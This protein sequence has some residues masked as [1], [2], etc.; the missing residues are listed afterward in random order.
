MPG[1]DIVTK[2]NPVALITGAAQRIGAEIART[3][4]RAGMDIAL[5]Y[6]SSDAAARQLK[7][8]LEAAR[9]HSVRLIQA[10]LQ[11]TAS[12]AQ[13][14]DRVDGWRGRL[15]LLV[16]NASSF[17]P[18]PLDSADRVQWQELMN[19]N[20]TAP[21]FLSLAAAPLLKKRRGSIVNLVDI[22][23]DRPL[24]GH[25]I[26]SIAK[27]GSAMMV[28]SLARELGPEIRVNGVA[29][30]AILWP[31]E[32]LDKMIRESVIQR[33]CLER[34][35]EP[36]DIAKTV[37]FLALEADY[38]TGQIVAVDGGRTVQQ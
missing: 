23:A 3:L 21:F 30:G 24:K 11:Q 19:I 7:Q 18:T 34:S 36:E 29:P 12:T 31:E 26:Y 15:D 14:I 17:H 22:Y 37:R 32:G 35:G 25:A 2:P 6:H 5:H 20:L 8:L 9:P 28:K 33:T 27:A 38:I 10:D 16:N 1:E 4:H 13:I